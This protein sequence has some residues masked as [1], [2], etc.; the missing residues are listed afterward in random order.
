MALYELVDIGANLGH[1]SYQ[2]DLNEVLDRA[3][4]AGL[5]KIM[6]TGTSETISHECAKLVEKHPGF[7]YF[8]AGVHPHDAKYWNDGTLEAL[9]ALQENPSCVAVGECG[10]DFN[11]NFSPQDVQKDVFAKQ[12][13][14]AVQLRKP[15]F[16]HE[17]E[18]HEDMVRILTEVGTSLPPAV[19]HCFTGTVDEAK[20][21]LEMGLYI[22]LTGFLWK[23]RS[24]NGVQAGL[25]SGNIPIEKLVL[26]TDAPYMYPKINDKKI[27]KEI[28]DLITP[29]TS[30][31]HKFSSF[32]RNEPC[33]LAAVCELIAAF[34]GRDPK[35]VA[36]ITTENAKRIYK[37]Q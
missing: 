35:E 4:L 31:L 12:V 24:D 28:K 5:S 10:L 23:D 3:K 2:K 26:E 17:R 1:P 6:V 25:R 14:L 15:L 16:I 7:L 27:P 13:S 9:K 20:K 36:R 8:T 37:L 34:S 33:S 29:E 21:Y 22:G 19:I 18:A 30:A 11:R 32:N